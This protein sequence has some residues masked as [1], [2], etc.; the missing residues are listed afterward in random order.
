MATIRTHEEMM[1]EAIFCPKS[2]PHFYCDPECT[3]LRKDT[4]KYKA[5]EPGERHRMGYYCG[6]GGEPTSEEAA[7]Y[8]EHGDPVP[9]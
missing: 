3:S 5:G 6:V 2:G 1:T 4:F 9:Q 7:E 8:A